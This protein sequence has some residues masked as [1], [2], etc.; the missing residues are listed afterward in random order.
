MLDFHYTKIDGKS[1]IPIVDLYFKN[2]VNFIFTTKTDFAVIDTGSDV[3]V[4]S[5]TVISKLRVR[6][7]PEPQQIHIKGFGREN[8]GIPYLV[9][10]GFS[11]ENYIYVKVF[12]IPDDIL[13]GQVIVGRD[14]LNNYVITFDDPN[15]VFTI[16]D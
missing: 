7:L 6:P 14:I 2:P 1:A 3:T 13:D 9:E 4:V 8:I 16:S 10:A 5:Y 11:N 12:A 15:L